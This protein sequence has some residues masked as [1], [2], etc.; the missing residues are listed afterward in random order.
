MLQVSNEVMELVQLLN[1][2]GYTILA[3]ELLTEI[4]LG[5]EPDYFDDEL[6]L[7]LRFGQSPGRPESEVNRVPLSSSEQMDFALKFLELRLVSP[8]RALAE[9]EEIAGKLAVPEGKA[10]PADKAEEFGRPIR[11]SFRSPPGRSN[12]EIKRSDVPGS[13]A[14]AEELSKALSN[15]R[16]EI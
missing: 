16:E 13:T 11:L 1:E 4:G 8:I 6:G 10:A 7:D 14:W 5:H 3:G 9:A 15:L 12:I 2:E